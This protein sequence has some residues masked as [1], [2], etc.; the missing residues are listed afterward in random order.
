MNNFFCN[1]DNNGILWLIILAILFGGSGCG[2]NNGCGG[3]GCG[4]GNNILWLLVL[5]ILFGGFGTCGDGC[6]CG[7]SNGCC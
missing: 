1:N 6:G 5:I 7:G 2:C 3:N 4:D